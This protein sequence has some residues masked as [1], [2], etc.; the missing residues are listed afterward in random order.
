MPDAAGF[1]LAW[2]VAVDAVP[3]GKGG[4]WGRPKGFGGGTQ[5]S[6]QGE[7]DPSTH[8][9]KG[10]FLGGDRCKFPGCGQPREA[11]TPE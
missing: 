8:E 6:E 7:E 2:K 10:S 5:G 3:N 1:G 4:A 11:H 9:F